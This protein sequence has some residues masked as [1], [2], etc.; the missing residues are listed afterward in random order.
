MYVS[1]YVCVYV[2]VCVCIAMWI[3]TCDRHLSVTLC[4][5]VCW[6]AYC[7]RGEDVQTHSL[8]DAPVAVLDIFFLK[9]RGVYRAADVFLSLTTGRKTFELDPS[10]PPIPMHQ[11][12]M[13][14]PR[15]ESIATYKFRCYSPWTR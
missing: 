13:S 3:S 12:S 8:V 4:V 6:Q 9:D 5:V 10:L 2:C 1:M 14:C 11:F 15:A 7:Q